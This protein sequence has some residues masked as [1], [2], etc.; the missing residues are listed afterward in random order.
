M[1]S[2]SAD[3]VLPP[4]FASPAYF[5]VMECDPALK[6]EIETPAE[7]FERY[8]TPS[9]VAPSKNVTCPVA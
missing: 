2:V 4:K 1:V 3:E 6:F 7:L 9:D 8:A 5:A